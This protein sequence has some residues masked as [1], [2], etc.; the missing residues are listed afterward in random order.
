[1]LKEVEKIEAKACPLFLS[2]EGEGF[3]LIFLSFNPLTPDA[4]YMRH[5]VRYCLTPNDAY[6]RH[7]KLPLFTIH[8][9]P[10][11][12]Q[13]LLL[14]VRKLSSRLVHLLTLRNTCRMGEAW[15]LAENNHH[16]GVALPA[17][18]IVL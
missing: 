18:Y 2:L 7:V 6:M 17:S 15:E 5:R 13:L 4:A 14:V 8:S 16:V 1:M 11:L 12:N 9:F 10:G 3:A